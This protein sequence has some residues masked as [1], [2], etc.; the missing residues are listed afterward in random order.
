LLLY[1]G[2]EWHQYILSAREIMSGTLRNFGLN[3]GQ[4]YLI[5]IVVILLLFPVC[6]GYQNYRANHPS[7]WWLRYL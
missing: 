3:L 1:Q 2:R 6:R 7:E 4:A 5:W